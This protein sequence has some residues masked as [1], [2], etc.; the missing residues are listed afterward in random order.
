MKDYYQA[1]GVW[2]IDDNVF[3]QT[4]YFIR[5]Y[6]TWQKM[7]DISNNSNKL[8]KEVE[9]T[10]VIAADAETNI[11]VVNKAMSNYVPVEFQKAVFAHIVDGLNYNEIEAKFGVGQ[12]DLKEYRARL[13]W[14]VAM[15]MGWIY[16]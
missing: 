4:F 5:Q 9:K 11:E 8:I 7:T 6:P 16:S 2:R 12:E 13:I 14:A 1:K 15:E 3:K 10:A